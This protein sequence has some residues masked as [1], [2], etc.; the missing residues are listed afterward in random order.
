MKKGKNMVFGLLAV[1]L[2]AI[3]VNQVSAAE[4]GTTK[5]TAVL[6][7]FGKKYT[8]SWNNM[9]DLYVKFTV[10]T[11]GM[12]TMNFSKPIDSRGERGRLWVYLYNEAGNKIWETRTRQAFKEPSLNYVF[13]VG[14]APGVY[15]AQLNY[16]DVKGY[17]IKMDYRFNFSSNPLVEVESN[18]TKASATEINL[19][20][21]YQATLG[22]DGAYY[23]SDEDYF[24]FNVT[25]GKEYRLAIK[26]YAKLKEKDIVIE[27]IDP[28]GKTTSILNSFQTIDSSELKYYTFK[29]AYSGVY[30]VKV[31][32]YNGL[33]LNY[34]IGVLNEVRVSY[35]TQIQNKGWI[36]KVVNG[37]TS[38]TMGSGLRMESLKVNLENP[39][40][41]GNIECRSHIQNRGWETTWKKN[42]EVSGTTGKGL[43]IEAIQ[44]RLSGAMNT[45]YDLYYRVHVQNIGWMGWAKNGSSAGS[46][47]YGYRIEA[48]QIKLVRKGGNAP[49]NTTNAYKV[50]DS[51]SVA[52]KTQV[53]NIG[54]MSEVRNG[55][56]AGTSGK[57]Y[58]LESLQASIK[59]SNY[60]GNIEY[61]SHIQNKGWES[62]WKKNGA[63][64]GTT[65]KGLRLEALQMRLTGDIANYYDLYYRVH[66]QNIGW[67]GWAKNGSYS[68]T[69]GYGYRIEAMQIKLVKKGG[70]APGSTANS[71]RSK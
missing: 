59:N 29:P 14:L 25:Q 67:M 20:Q 19:N 8:K 3:S 22:F 5:S 26:N 61:R 33:Q 4:L 16:F 58:R 66:V 52:Y 18:A 21:M 42:G 64:S 65:G 68:G 1:I 2:F 37:D 9:D 28:Y 10:N 17:P 27:L 70:S 24:K 15:Y 54:W 69:S 39:L 40:Y 32:Y 38:G 36:S 7:S 23:N 55:A 45:Y 31:S 43:R 44:M 35:Q 50:K 62:S 57:G 48:I 34:A 56:I 63:I 49:G 41:G 60:S 46:S 53:Q 12:V 30:Y 13:Q 51:S 71:Y 6:V 47:G 11:R